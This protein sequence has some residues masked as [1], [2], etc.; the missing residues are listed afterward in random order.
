MAFFSNLFKKKE[1][2]GKEENIHEKRKKAMDNLI[3]ETNKS[4]FSEIQKAA[5]LQPNDPFF[6]DI[7]N[8]E[9]FLMRN[10]VSSL[11]ALMAAD[12]LDFHEACKEIIEHADKGLEINP[13][14]A[15]L[16]YFRG[17]SKGDLGKFEEGLK[18]LNKCIKIK[19]DY[20]DAYVEQG[21]IKQKMGNFF[22][23]KKDYEK[24]INLDSSLQQQVNSYLYGESNKNVE[25]TNGR[26]YRA[27]LAIKQDGKRTKAFDNAVE[28]TKE[29]LKKYGSSIELDNSIT[30]LPLY[31]IL[32]ISKEFDSSK[33]NT[34]ETIAWN[35]FK[36]NIQSA[37]KQDKDKY[38]DIQVYNK[39]VY[40]FEPDEISNIPQLSRSLPIF[41][42]LPEN[43]LYVG[44]TFRI[45]TT[46]YDEILE[47]IRNINQ[48]LKLPK[49]DLKDAERRY[50]DAIKQVTESISRRNKISLEKA[51]KIVDDGINSGLI[52]TIYDRVFNYKL[53]KDV[54][55][56][57]KDYFIEISFL[58][59][60][61]G[62]MK[63]TKP[64]KE[65]QRRIKF[66]ISIATELEP[67]DENGY[68]LVLSDKFEIDSSFMENKL[69]K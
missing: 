45:I 42:D 55:K 59:T 2:E 47:I 14:S 56:Y 12:D 16:L 52:K 65:L 48:T 22:S 20:A 36:K 64:E 40:D 21:Y 13:N 9:E 23:A 32:L 43:K 38:K 17:R 8:K 33:G 60:P 44:Y 68:F 49:V 24:G 51:K 27:I 50:E 37:I 26:I 62:L 18:D 11:A 10:K 1:S 35:S 15:Y 34:E 30:E 5:K 58:P 66:G 7:K 53:L 41:E 6:Q 54:L 3:H 57:G 67:F 63:L 4:S 69:P 28:L 19:S 46:N 31:T 61:Q 25:R 29:V 39:I